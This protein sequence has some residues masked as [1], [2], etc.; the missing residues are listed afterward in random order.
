MGVV[1]LNG[2]PVFFVFNCIFLVFEH[3]LALLATIQVKSLE[4][5]EDSESETRFQK[6]FSQNMIHH[7][8]TAKYLRLKA[9]A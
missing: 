7:T 3:D 9:E 4:E 2:N 5:L 6:V 1:G 8:R